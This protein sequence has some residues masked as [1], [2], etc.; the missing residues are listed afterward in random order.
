LVINIQSKFKYLIYHHKNPFNPSNQSYRKNA[1]LQKGSVNKQ[2]IF[3]SRE[4]NISQK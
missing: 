2:Q 3:S 4:D 1:Y